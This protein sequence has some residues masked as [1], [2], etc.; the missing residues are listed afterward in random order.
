[1]IGYLRGEILESSEGKMLVGIGDSAGSGVVGYSV[2]VP[3]SHRY[4]SELPGR[5]IELFVHTHVREEAFDLY[6]FN[7]QMEKSLFLTL[8]S[9]N[10]IG[11]KSALGILSAVESSQ[12]VDAIVKGD[13]AL[14]SSIS[15]IGKKTAERLVLELRDKVKKKLDSGALKGLA[16][17]SKDT[18]GGRLKGD[19]DAN[20]S[21]MLRD[22]KSALV[23]LGYREMDVQL[24]LTQ[25]VENSE[26]P[27]K[28][29]EDL[30]RSALK[31]LVQ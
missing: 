16:S 22:A 27:F 30:I 23:G 19:Y 6:G 25:V 28:K 8:L 31:R 4:E 21:D 20:T 3:Q 13:Q 1:M 29:P 18:A 15:G 2:C 7:S 5:T 14:L 17:S 9:V 10:G 12:L 24:L 11:P 26:I